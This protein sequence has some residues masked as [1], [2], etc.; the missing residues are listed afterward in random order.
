MERY[1]RQNDDSFNTVVKRYSRLR[2][3]NP[4]QETLE[5]IA[6]VQEM[7][8]NPSLGKSYTDVDEMM[9]ELLS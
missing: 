4:S 6:E 8:M 1:V 5:A 9:K 3:K 7:K 2:S